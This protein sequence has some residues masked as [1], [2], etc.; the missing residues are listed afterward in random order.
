MLVFGVLYVCVGLA[1]LRYSSAASIPRR[2]TRRLPLVES[3]EK[4][5]LLALG[6]TRQ[7]VLSQIGAQYPR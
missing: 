7:L 6:F 1:N 2:L 3:A 4:V 5:S